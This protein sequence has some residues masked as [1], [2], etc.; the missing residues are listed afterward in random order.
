LET[1]AIARAKVDRAQVALDLAELKAAQAVGLA[2]E[3]LAQVRLENPAPALVA[4]EV[5]LERAKIALDA[6]QVEYDKVLD[7]PWEDPLV[8]DAIAKELRLAQLSYQLAQASVETAQADVDAWKLRVQ[9]AQA[10]QVRAR[11]L[12]EQ[13]VTEARTD[14][15]LAQ[16][17]LAQ[18]AEPP[19]EVELA[20]MQA[21]V[22]KAEVDLKRIQE[23]LTA[24]RIYAPFDGTVFVLDANVGDQVLAYTPIG[25][26]GDP[27]EVQ[28]LAYV[29]EQDVGGVAA[30]QAATVHLDSYTDQAFTAHVRQVAAQPVTWQ[31]RRAY[32]VTLA[33]EQADEVPPLLR[34]GC[35]CYIHAGAQSDVLTVPER[36]L[37]QQGSLTYVDVVEDGRVRRTSVQTG[38]LAAGRVEIVSGLREGQMVRVH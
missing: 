34:T 29:F 13:Q 18:L 4:A 20:I 36:A 16:A 19:S 7:R 24:T 25:I 23:R 1:L 5:K 2:A 37:Y 9:N 21:Q 28:V 26:V 32:P 6:A 11:A 31:G 3:A 33:F 38:T 8:R 15:S 27:T 10:E 35:D 22:K 17:E 14:L 12:A 30:G